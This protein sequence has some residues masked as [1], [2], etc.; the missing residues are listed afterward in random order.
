MNYYLLFKSVHILA[1]VAFLGNITTGLF[2][3]RFAKKTGNVQIMQHT[4]S[5]IIASDRIFTIPAVVII[6]GFGMGA[7]IHAGT[8]MLSTGWIFW[9]LVLFTLS[10]IIFAAKV[11]P[12]QVKMKKHLREQ[13]NKGAAGFDNGLFNTFFRQWEFWGFLALITPVISFFMM[14]FKWPVFSPLK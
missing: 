4:A 12:L 13:I 10:G 14:V 11:A 3:M 1:V 7:A 8:S 6:T 9:P 2:W 5:G